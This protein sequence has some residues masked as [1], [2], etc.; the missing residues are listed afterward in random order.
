[1]TRPT[2]A[3][4][5]GDVINEIERS[6]PTAAAEVR[7]ALSA[8]RVRDDLADAV[9]LLREHARTGTDAIAR[10]IAVLLVDYDEAIGRRSVAP[11]AVPVIPAAPAPPAGPVRGVAVD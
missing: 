1:M 8:K 7:A 9:S 2:P 10:A 11:R 4:P 5:I 6:N 3:R